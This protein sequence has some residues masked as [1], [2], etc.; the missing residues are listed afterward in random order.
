V[1]TKTLVY[2]YTVFFVF[3]G[4]VLC[5]PYQNLVGALPAFGGTIGGLFVAYCSAH[6]GEG[7]VN[8]SLPSQPKEGV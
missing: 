5:I 2:L 8:K 1:D 7:W 6:V 4:F 3:L